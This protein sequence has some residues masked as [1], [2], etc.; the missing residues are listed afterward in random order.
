MASVHVRTNFGA[1]AAG[2]IPS[3]ARGLFELFSLTDKEDP[4]V[5]DS[6][7]SACAASAQST[8]S[9][10]AGLHVSDQEGGFFGGKRRGEDFLVFF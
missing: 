5:S 2:S 6:S 9:Q 8:P 4:P 3:P 7:S 1:V 10:H